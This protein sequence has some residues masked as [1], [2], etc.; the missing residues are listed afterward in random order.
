MLIRRNST[1]KVAALQIL[2]NWAER[3]SQKRPLPYQK[4]KQRVI[5]SKDRG[6]SKVAFGV[7]ANH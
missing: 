2:S 4:T 1:N 3:G 5:K 7:F 6:I